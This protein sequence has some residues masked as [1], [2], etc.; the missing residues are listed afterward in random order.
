V[1]E[2]TLWKQ[3]N[4]ELR[5]HRHILKVGLIGESKVA[6]YTYEGHRAGWNEAQILKIE[7]NSSYKKYE[8]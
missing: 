2:A 3:A 8:G 6:Q 1:A 4:H 7:A 5:R